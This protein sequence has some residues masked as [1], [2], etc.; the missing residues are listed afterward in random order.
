MAQPSPVRGAGKSTHSAADVMVVHGRA[1][2]QGRWSW[3]EVGSMGPL[4]S[5]RRHLRPFTGIYWHL[6]AIL[7]YFQAK[8]RGSQRPARASGPP[9]GRAPSPGF[10]TVL[11]TPSPPWG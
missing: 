6:L 3:A 11:P 8:L 2:V 9:E 5:V 7:P 10:A 1:K 4:G